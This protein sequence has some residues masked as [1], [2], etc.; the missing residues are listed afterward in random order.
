[1]QAV[2]NRVKAVL[3]A[4][5]DDVEA[6]LDP[7]LQ[8]A[9]QIQHLRFT[10]VANNVEVRTVIALQV[11]GRK[12]VV[13]QLFDIHTIRTRHDH[14][15]GRAFVIRLIAK[16]LH[17][18]QFLG[19]HLRG[20]LFEHLGRRDLVRQSRDDDVAVL[21]FPHG[22]HLDRTISGLVHLQQFIAGRNDLRVGRVVRSEHVLAQV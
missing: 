13:H 18:R 17:H 15:P 2:D 16:I 14:Q 12:Q 6:E 9:A 4:A 22:A 7:L 10:V 11:G 1:M 5:R 21:F 20:D 19:S 8:Q 3:K